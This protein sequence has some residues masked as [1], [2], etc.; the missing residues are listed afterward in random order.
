MRRVHCGGRVFCRRNRRFG[1]RVCRG[2]RPGAPGRP[3]WPRWPR[4][5]RWPRLPVVAA[6]VA[7]VVGR[8]ARSACW[9]LTVGAPDM[10]PIVAPPTFA[11]TIARAATRYGAIGARVGTRAPVHVAQPTSTMRA[12]AH[13][14]G[15][16]RIGSPARTRGGAFSIA[17][18]SAALAPQLPPHHLTLAIGI[19]F[20][21]MA[22]IPRVLASAR[23]V[24]VVVVVVV[25]MIT[26]IP[27]VVIIFIAG[28]R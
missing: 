12:H 2:R 11:H 1:W 18:A 26:I 20:A 4:R 28:R 3:R 22:L 15:C 6:T 13:L 21:S 19:N 17:F 10:A 23:V 27:I 9:A 25:V 16:G 5:P 7:F 24:V 8:V 14:F